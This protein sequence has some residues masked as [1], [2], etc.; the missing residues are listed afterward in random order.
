MKMKIFIILS[1]L[2]FPAMAKDYKDYLVHVGAGLIVVDYL[3]TREIVKNPE[4]YK[5]VGLLIDEQPTMREIN[6]AYAAQI[7]AH[8]AA[9]LYFKGDANLIYNSMMIGGRL[10]AVIYNRRIGITI[11]W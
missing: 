9:D 4:K 10:I 7:A 6:Q 5:E 3:Q 11:Q 1:L 8:Y 2:S